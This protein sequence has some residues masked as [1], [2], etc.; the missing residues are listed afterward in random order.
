MMV[1]TCYQVRHFKALY[2]G[3]CTTLIKL[4]MSTI[5]I[6]LFSMFKAPIGVINELEQMQ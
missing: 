3:D 6:Y 1:E 5:G 4:V 2:F